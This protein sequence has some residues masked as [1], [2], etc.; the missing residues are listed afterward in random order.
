MAQQIILESHMVIGMIAQPLAG[1]CLW[2]CGGLVDDDAERQW[3]GWCHI[4]RLT[5]VGLLVGA[6]LGL[7]VAG[8]MLLSSGHEMF[9]LAVLARETFG[10]GVMGAIG[11]Y[12][13]AGV[14]WRGNR[15]NQ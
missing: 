14:P 8:H 4:V 15:L 13:I 7:Q 10:V 6:G 1:L 12:L 9:S 2:L 5:G 3:G 11:A